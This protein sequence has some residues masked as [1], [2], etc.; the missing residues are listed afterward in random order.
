[1]RP[2]KLADSCPQARKQP[3]LPRAGALVEVPHQ[4]E[5]T[6]FVD[7]ELHHRQRNRVMARTPTLVR[8]KQ[9]QG[10]QTRV[11][12]LRCRTSA[13]EHRATPDNL[14][15]IWTPHENRAPLARHVE[16]HNPNHHK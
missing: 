16:Q 12:F 7:R 11:R 5:V 10:A 6:Q 3:R 8:G 13:A 2:S 9:A 1:M 4:R 15:P 14:D